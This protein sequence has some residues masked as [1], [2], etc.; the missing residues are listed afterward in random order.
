MFLNQ[1][2]QVQLPLSIFLKHKYS[3]DLVLECKVKS[4]L[5]LFKLFNKIFNF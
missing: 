1:L 4:K 2:N 5:L 3:K